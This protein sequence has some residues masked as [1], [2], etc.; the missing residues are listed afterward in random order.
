MNVYQP[1]TQ[2]IKALNSLD[3]S[4]T[5][6]WLLENQTAMGCRELFFLE[7]GF[8]TCYTVNIPK[9]TCR[10]W[11]RGNQT[12]TWNSD[13][14][15]FT[16]PSTYELNKKHKNCFVHLTGTF[17]D[18]HKFW[19]QKS[20]KENKQERLKNWILHFLSFMILKVLILERQ[21]LTSLDCSWYHTSK[22]KIWYH[23]ANKSIIVAQKRQKKNWWQFVFAFL[24]AY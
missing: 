9:K 1:K 5:Y 12:K 4:I 15:F 2:L 23:K 21:Y 19:R 17:S 18:Q 14:T 13:L 3:C 6:G 10:F 11:T 16:C 20:K 24:N 22:N 7:N 8:K